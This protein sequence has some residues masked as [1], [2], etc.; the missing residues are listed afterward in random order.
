MAVDSGEPI[1][2]LENAVENLA[3]NVVRLTG[4]VHSEFRRIHDRFDRLE[5]ELSI[6]STSWRPQSKTAVDP[7][8]TDRDYSLAGAGASKPRPNRR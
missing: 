4:N 7:N 5:S 1:D 8:L 2:R 3:D 6:D